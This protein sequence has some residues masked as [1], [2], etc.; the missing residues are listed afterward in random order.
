MFRPVH[1]LTAS[2]LRCF[3]DVLNT[4]VFERMC[5][6]VVAALPF[7]LN[8]TGRIKRCCTVSL[9]SSNREAR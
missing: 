5:L 1:V 4:S 3:F 6:D 8:R 2:L 9:R 7:D